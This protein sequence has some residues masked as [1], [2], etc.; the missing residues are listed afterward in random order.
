MSMIHA[1]GICT[2]LYDNLNPQRDARDTICSW[3]FKAH[4]NLIGSSPLYKANHQNALLKIMLTM[5]SWER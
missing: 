3:A 5:K 4:E 1:E 2:I